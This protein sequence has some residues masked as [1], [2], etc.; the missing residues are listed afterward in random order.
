MLPSQ[1]SQVLLGV[2]MALF[3]TGAVVGVGIASLR[4]IIG[5]RSTTATCDRLGFPSFVWLGF[6]T[7]QGIV[8]VAWLTL[9]LGGIFYQWPIW[10]F[11]ALGFL[12]AG[13][14]AHLRQRRITESLAKIRTSFLS[15]LYSRSW[16]FCVASG[17]IIVIVLGGVIALLPTGIDDALRWYLVLPNVVATKHRLELLPFLAPYYGLH[18]LQVEMHWAALFAI[19]NETAVT[20]WDYLCALSSLAGIG[21]LAWAVTSNRRVAIVAILM[22]LSTS[23]F[24]Q[25][26][27]GGKPDN[28]AVQYGIAAF[29]WLILW[30]AL[31]WRSIIMGGLCAGW[32]LASRY[33]NV[34]LLPGLIMFALVAVPRAWKA[35]PLEM[36][37]EHKKKSW[38]TNVLIGGIAAGLAVAPMFIKNWLLLGCPLA[39]VFGCQ[40]TT[41]AGITWVKSASWIYNRQSISVLDLLSYPVTWTFV[42]GPNSLGNISPL[43]LG[44]LPFVL[45]Y[46]R[47]PIVR[48]GLIAG[49][50]GLLSIAGWWLFINGLLPYARWMLLPLALFAIYLS[51]SAVAADQDPRVARPARW[52]MRGTILTLLLFLLFQSREIVYAIRY[53]AAIDSRNSSYESKSGYDVAMW[54]NTHMQ[55]GQRVALGGWSGYAYFLSPDNLINSES[56]NERQ[57]LWQLC[58]CRAPWRWTADFWRFYAARSFNYVVVAKEVVTHAVSVLPDHIEV[59]VAFLG[60]TD[61]V[62]RLE[63]HQPTQIKTAARAL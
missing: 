40:D 61:A 11:C 25:L 52:L 42:H 20:F 13:V 56:V 38:L 62:L 6:V 24:Y 14:M 55:L 2:L 29:L 5:Y 22:M 17:L 47:S 32:S 60:K 8:S 15:L 19:S 53:V 36:A 39:P 59:E 4:A 16:Y 63:N 31:G 49:L 54:L 28:A 27:G 44:F 23:A 48:S 34:F 26:M 7:G 58:R 10:I 12:L 37:G 30:P 9:S 1:T 41:W 43:F 45:F 50:A 33:T 46:Y 51:A 57:S 21:V 18:P 3:Y 35:S